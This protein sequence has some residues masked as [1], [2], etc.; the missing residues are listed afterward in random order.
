MINWIKM[1]KTI[2]LFIILIAPFNCNTELE[3]GV[4]LIPPVQN[5]VVIWGQKQIERVKKNF[6]A[7]EKETTEYLK[8]IFAAAN[9]M[10]DTEPDPQPFIIQK[11]NIGMKEVQRDRALAQ[12]FAADYVFNG[13]KKSFEK[14]RQF[15]LA[16]ASTYRTDRIETGYFTSVYQLIP[17]IWAYELI[18][19]SLPKEDKNKIESFFR[20]VYEIAE[21]NITGEFSDAHAYGNHWSYHVYTISAIGFLL[22]DDKIIKRAE[23]VYNEQIDWNLFPGGTPRNFYNNAPKGKEIIERFERCGVADKYFEKSTYDWINRDALGYH[24]ISIERLLWAGWFAENSGRK[25]L[26]KKGKQGMMLTDAFD[27]LIQFTN[28]RHK[29]FANT[30]IE[31]DEEKENESWVKQPDDVIRALAS[32]SLLHER[33]AKWKNTAYGSHTQLLEITGK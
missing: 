32:A 4:D 24:I 29:E 23:E 15:I 21:A 16:W 12:A 17:F 9:K 14:S 7:G 2:L 13:N 1:V 18:K 26:S 8:K 28:K 31:G 30:C 20:N 27:L 3:S 6:S 11:K 22:N 25:W 33:F 19:S 5:G 10:K